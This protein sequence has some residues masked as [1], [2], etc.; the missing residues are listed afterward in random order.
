MPDGL[1]GGVRR[2]G[3][4]KTAITHEALWMMK[5]VGTP[6]VSPD[7]RWVV[8]SVMEPSYEQTKR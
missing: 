3:C 4:P 1:R 2:H 7:G 8:F 5:R 6:T